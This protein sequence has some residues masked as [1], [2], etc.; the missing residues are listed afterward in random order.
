MHVPNSLNA[1]IAKLLDSW[2]EQNRHLAIAESLTGGLV[3]SRVVEVPGASRVFLGSIV[4]YQN[5]LKHELLGVSK[6]LLD[7]VGAVDG[8]VAIQMAAGVRKQLSQG[9]NEDAVIG[10]A[11]TGVAGPGDQD[12]LPAGTAFVAISCIEGDFVYSLHLD[13]NRSEIREMVVEAS[14]NALWEHFG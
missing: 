14:V 4:A 3:S 1:K 5:N 9:L 8:R 10:L 2:F 7:Q 6:S 11:T 12:G 13:G